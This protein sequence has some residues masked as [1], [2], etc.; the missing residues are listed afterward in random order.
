MLIAHSTELKTHLPALSNRKHSPT[1]EGHILPTIFSWYAMSCLFTWLSSIFETSVVPAMKKCVSMGHWIFESC[2]L[3]DFFVGRSPSATFNTCN[4][5]QVYHMFRG[6]LWKNHR[7]KFHLNHSQMLHVW[8][9]CLSTC[10]LDLGRFN[11]GSENEH[12]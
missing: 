4:K 9:L 1:N 7:W 12:Q 6:Q 10:I 3:S 8:N 2:H 11:K 5:K